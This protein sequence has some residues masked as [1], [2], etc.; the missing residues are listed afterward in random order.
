MASIGKIRQKKLGFKGKSQLAGIES[1]LPR[2]GNRPLR[3][4]VKGKTQLAG[5]ESPKRLT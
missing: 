2:F 3:A 1:L 5:I 4:R